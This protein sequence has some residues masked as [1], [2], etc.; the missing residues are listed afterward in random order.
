MPTGAAWQTPSQ[1]RELNQ[2]RCRR[3]K[4]RASAMVIIKLAGLS[5]NLGL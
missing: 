4:T 5:F 3:F 1:H 2:S